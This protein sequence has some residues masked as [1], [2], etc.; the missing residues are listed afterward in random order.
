M[1]RKKSEAEV[2]R[3]YRLTHTYTREDRQRLRH[4]GKGKK[5]QRWLYIPSG[6]RAVVLRAAS[7]LRRYGK[8]KT[9]RRSSPESRGTPFVVVV[10]RATPRQH[11]R[12]VNAVMMRSGIGIKEVR[13]GGNRFFRRGREKGSWIFVLCCP[14][15]GV[16]VREV[17][18][19]PDEDTVGPLCKECEKMTPLERLMVGATAGG[20]SSHE[21]DEEE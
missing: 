1:A 7:A 15:C 3:A 20:V 4:G 21:D 8:G 17:S 16:G 10:L 13:L 2:S 19:P 18:R 11:L 14:V 9:I 6:D 5:A 12:A